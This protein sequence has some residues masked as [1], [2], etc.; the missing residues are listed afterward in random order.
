MK[1]LF[2]FT[3]K[4]T[5]NFDLAVGAFRS[6]LQMGPDP[7]LETPVAK[8]HVLIVGCGLGG[9]AA[10]VSIRRA[11][12]DVIVLE[13]NAQ[14]QEVQRS[15]ELHEVSY[16][17]DVSGTPQL[18]AGINITPNAT[19]IL[20]QFGV[21]E[22]IRSKANVPGSAIMRSYKDGTE[23]SRVDLGRSIEDMYSAPYMVIHRADLHSILLREAL[24]LGVSI[25]LNSQ[26][27]RFNLCEPSVD[28]ASG[29][30][31]VAD[32]VIGADGERSACRGALIGHDIPARDCGDHVFRI[33]VP[34]TDVLQHQHL[35]G[36]VDPPC[37]NLWVGPGAHAMTYALKR[38]SL[39]NIVLTCAH[40]DSHD[41]R[42]GPKF[43]EI[44]EAQE[45]F[46]D[47]DQNF[48]TLLGLAQACAKWTLLHPPTP[49]YWVHTEGRFAL[50][51]DSAHAMLPFM[52]V[53]S[54]P[55]VSTLLTPQ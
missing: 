21:L 25:R 54:P 17:T 8:C 42:P 32:L 36:L 26:I 55:L 43:V 10:A 49:D 48:Q 15:L 51:G 34:I 18:G 12:H 24:R 16:L 19:S 45:A 38:D 50:L 14:L 31:Y 6:S 1:K 46:K 2:L 9:L 3:I 20:D 11:G 30:K 47:W 22:D 44:R 4:G 39:L 29:E 40:D 27:V 5:D 33:T 13:K 37:I 28:L 52:Y 35:A 23:L 7:T 41:V 53:P